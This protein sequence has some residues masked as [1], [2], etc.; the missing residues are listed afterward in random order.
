MTNIRRPI[1]IPFPGHVANKDHQRLARWRIGGRGH[2]VALPY[3]TK[4]GVWLGKAT[5]GSVCIE[6]LQKL[7]GE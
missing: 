3:V 2:S 7:C 6:E 1:G 5:K 4:G